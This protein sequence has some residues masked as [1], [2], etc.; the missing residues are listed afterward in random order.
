MLCRLSYGH[1][2]SAK[3]RMSPR[4]A[5]RREHPGFIAR[6]F[7][8]AGSLRNTDTGWELQAQNPMGEGMLVGVGR[9]HVDG[10]EIPPRASLPSDPATRA[11]PRQDVSRTVRSASS[12]ATA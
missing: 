11:D 4:L 7:Y 9:M 3:Y 12:R 2:G 1:R 5:L 8:V 6:Q 10:R